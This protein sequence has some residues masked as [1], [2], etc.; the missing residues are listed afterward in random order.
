MSAQ[1]FLRVL[2]NKRI[3]RQHS[4]DKRS[5]NTTKLSINVFQGDQTHIEHYNG[6]HDVIYTI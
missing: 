1:V 6:D 2:S 3:N 4:K 5:C